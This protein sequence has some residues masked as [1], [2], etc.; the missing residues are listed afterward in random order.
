MT[1]QNTVPEQG[2]QRS[3]TGFT[4]VP[5]GGGWLRIVLAVACV[6]TMVVLWV[7]N[8][9]GTQRFFQ[10]LFMAAVGMWVVTRPGSAAPAVLMFGAL[11]LRIFVADPVLDGSLVGLVF[12]LPLVHQMA[13]LSA[14]IPLRANLYWSAL[15]PTVM[16]YFAAV[17]LTVVGLTGSHLVGWW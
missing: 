11:C 15:L 14:V 2:E 9:D 13:A 3:L 4:V 16:R 17:L 6:L 8:L 1:L 10:L 5:G 12:L 7:P